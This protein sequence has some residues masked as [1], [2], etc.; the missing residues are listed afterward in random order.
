M[1]KIINILGDVNKKGKFQIPTHKIIKDILKEYSGG[2]KNSRKVKLVQVGGPLGVCIKGKELNKKLS[3]YEEYMTGNMITF[4][5][6]LLCPVDY[7]RFLTR[8]MIREL[9]I[10]N[11]HI[12]KLNELLENIAQ[13]KGTKFDFEELI[14]E[15]N[16]EGKTNAEDL[17]HKIFI[18]ITSEFKSEFMEHI[19]DRK[20]KNGICRGLMVA[21]CMNACPAEVY[22][23]GYIELMKDD[24]V[25]EAYNL[26]RKNNPLSFVCGKVCA[27]P[28]EDRCRRGEIES[29]VGVRALKTYACDMTLKIGEYKEDKLDSK[30]KKVAIIG[31]GPAGLTAAYY[32]AKTGYEVVIYEAA[33]VVGGM[34]AMGIPEYRLP[35]EIIDKEIKLIKGLGVK[36]KTN[37]RVGV[38]ITLK[39]LRVIFDSVLLATGCHI[40]NKFGPEAPEI[41][42]AVDLLREVK[43]Q[44]RRE[45]GEN[46]LVI[47]GG[48]VAMDAARTS[49]R[50]GAKKVM[51]ASLETFDT[52]PASDEEKYGSVEEGVQFI[53]G[54]GTK[55]IHVENGKLRGITLKRCLS[56]FDDEGRFSPVYDE[57]DVKTFEIDSLILAIGQRPDN[58]Y[59]DEDIELNERGY[60]KV[61]PYT[62]ETNVE[63]VFAAGDMYT[64]GIAIKAIAEGKKAAVSID[65]YLGGKG[66]YLGEEIEIPEKPLN[67][68]I[69]DIEKTNEKHINP[70]ERKGNFNVVSRVYTEDEAKQ[71]A[72]RCMRC[73]RNSRK[74]LYLK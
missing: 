43:V 14:N 28:C 52:M 18:Y 25:E 69:W 30:G 49:I 54:Y 51:V 36:I 31:S 67:C 6:D 20:C 4:F 3:D 45:I 17:L 9:R 21:Q 26:M 37:T 53:S 44:G 7:L 29:T 34:L 57:D 12:R 62:F 33:K 65:K 55:D 61:N 64:P 66:L 50:L 58:S 40:G 41:E 27:R 10:D 47:G 73:D 32:L 2:M 22:I 42:T 71:E 48:D 38:D 19:I 68:T 13:G 1:N 56:I 60:I 72:S 11:E 63:G 70:L 35:Q 15:V 8:F 23:P 74:L 24:K 16:K 39:R 59:L 46:V 5:S